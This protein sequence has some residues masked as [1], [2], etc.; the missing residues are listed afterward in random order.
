MALR[1]KVVFFKVRGIIQ[2]VRS[3]LSRGVVYVGVHLNLVTFSVSFSY[4]VKCIK[5]TVSVN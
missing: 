4:L 1:N 5:M 2:L 3:S